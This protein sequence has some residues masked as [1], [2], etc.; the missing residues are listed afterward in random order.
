MPSGDAP[1][2]TDSDESVEAIRLDVDQR[3]RDLVGEISSL[4]GLTR[5][6]C[7]GVLQQLSPEKFAFY[8][9]NPSQFIRKVAEVILDHKAAGM[10]AGAEYHIR[11][12]SEALDGD[13]VFPADEKVAKRVSLA[14]SREPQKSVLRYLP[15][16][17]SALERWFALGYD[18]PG[19]DARAR[20]MR[21]RFDPG[22]DNL[23]EVL[24]WA[25]LPK[26]EFSIRTPLGGYTPDWAV[27]ARSPHG[28]I[29][30]YLVIETKSTTRQGGL[31]PDEKLR[32]EAAHKHF[33]ALTS[34]IGT[35]DDGVLPTTV[36]YHHVNSLSVVRD[37]IRGLSV[38]PA[39]VSG[40]GEVA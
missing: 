35:T 29:D 21:E 12:A 9:V 1:D 38:A 37:Q 10:V 16:L 14:D 11:D 28:G 26:P 32:I 3:P 23:E 22:L 18:K 8:R 24:A 17:D 27:A 30:V 31:R 34:A 2:S 39:T 15:P 13:K 25:K 5:A 19:E 33:A 6:T 4:S 36:R 20:D 7:F 40:T